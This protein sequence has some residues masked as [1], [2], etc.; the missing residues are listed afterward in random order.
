MNA[1]DF[2]LPTKSGALS[3][4]RET[5]AAPHA[6]HKSAEPFD[7]MMHRALARPERRPEEKPPAV[8]PPPPAARSSHAPKNTP[9]PAHK[10]KSAASPETAATAAEPGEPAESLEPAEAVE[11]TDRESTPAATEKERSRQDADSATNAGPTEKSE[12]LQPEAVEVAPL[13]LQSLVAA[14]MVPPPVVLTANSTPAGSVEASPVAGLTAEK[15]AGIPDRSLGLGGGELP[16]PAALQPAAPASAAPAALVVAG[17]IAETIVMPAKNE[18]VAD[19][20]EVSAATAAPAKNSGPAEFAGA[21][22]AAT[23]TGEDGRET[24]VKI[25]NSVKEKA[26]SPLAETTGTSGAKQPVKM[27]HAERAAQDAGTPEQPLPGVTVV[28]AQAAAQPRPAGRTAARLESSDAPALANVSSADRSPSTSET[29]S[30]SLISASSQTELRIRA[31]DRTHDI[32]ALQGLRLKETNAGSLHVVIKP[33]AGLELS[34]QLKQNGSGI[35]AM[36]ILQQGDFQQLNQ[37]WPDLQQRLEE[38]GIKLAPLGQDGAAT[39]GGNQNF[40]RPPQPSAEQNPLSAGAFAEFASAGA[41]A[42]RT[43]SAP[44]VASRGWEGWA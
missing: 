24:P 11:P 35:E 18:A 37:H 4:E 9:G 17:K 15:S 12:P 38:R 34:L 3:P 27:K 39:N 30:N 32:L 25:E 20:Q 41:A 26:A 14:F 31:L 40:Q 33:G 13:A 19:R 5:S 28:A 8:K 16:S 44:A 43:L 21:F 23:A 2:I 6:G 29:S 7:S 22:E 1:F 10:A 42:G 36:A